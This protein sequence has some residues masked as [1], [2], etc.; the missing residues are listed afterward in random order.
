MA[1]AA[2]LRARDA[3][4]PRIIAQAAAYPATDMTL[5]YGGAPGRSYERY[6]EG[7][8]LT[9][10]TM[11]WFAETYLPEPAEPGRGRPCRRCS[12]PTFGLPPA[13]IATAEYD[14]LSSEGARYAERLRAAGVPVTYLDGKGLVH[15]FL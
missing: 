13:V 12:R 15:G 2:A 9:A 6:A 5:G 8:G 11:H 4:G 14:P 1:L 3:G 7:Y 10:A